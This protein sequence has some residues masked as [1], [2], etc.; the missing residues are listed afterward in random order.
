MGVTLDDVLGY[1]TDS[2]APIDYVN[3]AFFE[4]I[5]D[6]SGNDEISHG[7]MYINESSC[8]ISG[9][10]DQGYLL[11]DTDDNGYYRYF[12]FDNIDGNGAGMPTQEE[13]SVVRHSVLICPKSGNKTVSIGKY[14]TQEELVLLCF[15][16]DSGEIRDKNG[17]TV[18]NEYDKDTFYQLDVFFNI[19]DNAY[20]IYLDSIEVS[21]GTLD[22]TPVGYISY[23]NGAAGAEMILKNISTNIYALGTSM[24][25]V[26]A[27]LY[28]MAYIELQDL[29]VLETEDGNY[30][31]SAAAVFN[32]VSKNYTDPQI[33]YALYRNNVLLNVGGTEITE[34]V[35]ITNDEIGLDYSE[36]DRKYP[37][38][39]MKTDGAVI[40]SGD[41]LTVK[42]WLF[43][44]GNSQIHLINSNEVSYTIE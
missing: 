42:A 44:G 34:E 33:V 27:D 36:I 11:A 29:T 19:K 18:I 22:Y 7:S 1:L 9:D 12:L 28:G 16:E 8:G 32:N 31:I 13:D 17:N 3:G 43:A 40:S 38:G 4:G 20:S 26:I 2:F 30:E 39:L 35:P 21:G 23:E 10:N 25:A 24:N 37:Y 14:S 41:V 5:N 6:I 15:D